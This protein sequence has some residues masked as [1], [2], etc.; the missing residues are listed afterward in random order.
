MANIIQKKRLANE[1]KLLEKEPL[2]YITAYP[3]KNNE[4]IWYFMIKGQKDTIYEN[5]EYIGKIEHSPKY[6]AEP[7]AYTM[8][9]PSGRYEINKKICLTN[10][11]F[12][13]GDWNPLW[14]IKTILIGFYSIFL[15]DDTTGIAHIHDSNEKRLEYAIKSI[16]YNKKFLNDID[17]N[18][19][20]TKLF[21]DIP[22]INYN[23]EIIN[24]LTNIYNLDNDLQSKI[25]KLL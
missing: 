12:H 18:F 21:N 19:D 25:N 2:H 3:D 23:E 10:S 17:S 9:T 11:N 16:D 7:P 1:V 14:N 24:I 6:P 5:G 20:K 8:L 22:K 13:R 4:L 15:A